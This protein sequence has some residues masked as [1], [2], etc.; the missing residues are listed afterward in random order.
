MSSVIASDQETDLKRRK[1]ISEYFSALSNVLQNPRAKACFYD[2]LVKEINQDTVHFLNHMEYLGLIYGV[3]RVEGRE[4]LE[5]I[6]GPLIKQFKLICQNSILIDAK[7]KGKS[8]NLGTKLRSA[9]KDYDT[10]VFGKD[11]DDEKSRVEAEAITSDEYNTRVTAFYQAID[12]QDK[13][14]L[15]GKSL[16]GAAMEAVL[17][18]LNLDSFQRFKSS[19]AFDDLI[20]G[21]V[22]SDILLDG[23]R[24]A[25]P[26]MLDEIRDLRLKIKEYLDFVDGYEKN[27][28]DVSKVEARDKVVFPAICLIRNFY[29]FLTTGSAQASDVGKSAV[30]K[31]ITIMDNLTTI[32]ET[33]RLDVKESSEN[34]GFARINSLLISIKNVMTKARKIGVC[35]STVSD[36]S[37][38]PMLEM[39]KSAI[40]KSSGTTGRDS[41]AH[42]KSNGLSKPTSVTHTST[43]GLPPMHPMIQARRKNSQIIATIEGAFR[44][45]DATTAS[46]DK[47]SV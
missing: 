13:D 35:T 26:V 3:E 25:A 20:D 38:S 15:S 2:V 1:D 42:D 11:K 6:D 37:A 36:H 4:P 5:A 10:I 21:F 19:R 7:P 29:K 17:L 12:K 8:E 45:A 30:Q 18:L 33:L 31:I 44:T 40:R 43:P 23:L 22:Q 27:T 32:Q 46:S 9:G 16:F 14:L 28:L 24:V 41:P 34:P 47:L 39:F